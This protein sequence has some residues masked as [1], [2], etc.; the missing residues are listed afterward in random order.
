MTRRMNIAKSLRT[1]NTHETHHQTDVTLDGKWELPEGFE[2]ALAGK[3]ILKHP[4][5]IRASRNTL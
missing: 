3:Y 5:T 1:D 2:K 4:E